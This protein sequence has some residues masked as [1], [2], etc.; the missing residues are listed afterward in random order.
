M[1]ENF[2][3][4][5]PAWLLALIPIAA[6]AWYWIKRTQSGSG[7]ESAVDDDLLNVLLD[8][9]PK[10]SHRWMRFLLL[11][12]LAI[13]A[14]GLSG[15]TWE[16]LP[17]NVEQKN[18]ALIILLDLSLSMLAED[19]KPSRMERARQKITDVLRLREEGQ[20]ALIG[21]AGDAHAVVPLTDDTATITNLLASLS[22][23]MMPVFGSNPDHAIRLA[24]ELFEN[25][26]IQQGR[27][28]MVTDGIDNINSVSRHRNR[29]YPIS[30]LGIGT[31]AGGPIPL[32]RVRQPGRFLLTQEGN[33]IIALLDEERLR[34][35]AQ[36]TYGHYAR[37]EIGDADVLRALSVPLPGEDETIEVER[38]FD[39][40]LD[41]GHWA[42][43]LLLPLVLLSFRKGVFVCFACT[44]L[45]PAPQAH[46]NT[47][48]DIWDSLWLRSDQRGHQALRYGEPEK[49]VTLF[50]GQSQWQS[51]AQYRSGDYARS[52]LGFRQD[53]TV[54][55]RYNEGNS[56]ARLGEYEAA[57]ASYEQVLSA[58]PEHEDAL[59]NKELVERLLKEQQQAQQQQDQD[60]QSQ[61]NNQ[62]GENEQSN[63]QQQQDQ[64]EQEQESD[65]SEEREQEK[66]DDQRGNGQEGTSHGLTSG[67]SLCV[68]EQ[69]CHGAG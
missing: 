18:D 33:R 21:Y 12:A 51:V 68:G 5:R 62:D 15:P 25:S 11:L 13:T 40:W 16:K 54:T 64:S 14:L 45:L 10:R 46:A 43:L 24:H 32:D 34:D 42:A 53:A 2:H 55:G 8:S 63:Q 9:G 48:G 19:I 27:I 50:D 44:L 57:I 23:E 20:T 59:F 38:E 41:Q 37:A 26:F 66:S 61:A 35:M 4:L 39:T 22:P 60:Q 47:A 17:Q 67:A 30:I 36:M 6:L 52:L 31:A 7:W 1:I 29:A 28:L 58:Q 3:L 65:N 69:R 49:A 56:L